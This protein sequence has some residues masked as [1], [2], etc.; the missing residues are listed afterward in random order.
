VRRQDLRLFD[1]DFVGSAGVVGLAV[2]AVEEEGETGTCVVSKE[3]TRGQNRSGRRRK[4]KDE[5][6]G[7]ATL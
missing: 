1:D 3:R 5:P 7:Y 6:A 4:G 2:V